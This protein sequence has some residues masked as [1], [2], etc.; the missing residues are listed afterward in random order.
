MNEQKKLIRVTTVPSS[1]QVL[2]RQQLHFMNDHY[3]VLAVSSPG[4]ELEQVAI[5]EGVR[6]SAVSMTRA[7]TP[8]KDAKA[9]WQL[10][11]LFKKEKP[12]IVHTHT[13]K[14]GLLGMIAGKMARVP[15]R[16]H[17]VAG[18][19]LME[20]TGF[21][22]KVLEVVE[23]ITYGCATEVYPNS[24]NLAAFIK[25]NRFCR[26]EKLKVLGNGSSNGID[27]EYFTL[28]KEIEDDATKLKALLNIEAGDFVFVFIGRLVKD[29]GIQELVKAFCRLQDKYT[30]AKLL[31][32]GPFEPE[33]DPLS[34]ETMAKININNAIITVG[35]QDDV[36]P[37]LAISNALAFPSY[38]EGFPNVPMQA[39]LFDLP[40]IVTNING[41][42]EIV[43]QNKNGILIPTKNTNALE[44]AMAEMLSNTKLY[45]E[46]K[47]NARKMIL[48][49]F[50]QKL[51]W[52]LLLQEYQNKTTVHVS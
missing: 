6:T 16:L 34:E 40:C 48:E 2:L 18:L 3:D 38:R 19:P 23:R 21:T 30:N 43:E 47:S 11:K 10:Y 5:Q 9:L 49:R 25:T 14:A 51:I 41:C 17:T 7:I 31:L 45:E 44:L 29:K 46:L 37:Y 22:R 4:K 28:N 52:K 42:N 8:V 26:D 15:V 32:V 24:T 27:T 1:L 20:V 12:A 35:F 50:D 36:R 39:G 33:L 13:P